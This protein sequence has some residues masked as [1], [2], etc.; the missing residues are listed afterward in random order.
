MSVR[1]VFIF[2]LLLIFTAGLVYCLWP[3]IVGLK[4]GYESHVAVSEFFELA[5]T[6]E[7]GKPGVSFEYVDAPVT[8]ESVPNDYPELFAAMQEYNENIYA[9]GQ[10]GL[11]DAWAYQQPSFN[12]TA[13]GVESN[14]IGV[15]N[16]PAMNVELPIYLGATSENMAAGAVHL[17]Q[18]S[19]P[20]GGENTNCVIAAHRGWYGAPYFR[21][22]DIL[23]IG[24]EV[25]ITNLWETLTYRVAEVKIIDPDD[26]DE[27]LIQ[28]GRELLTL[29]TCHPYAS[30]GLYRYVVY[31]ERVPS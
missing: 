14:T 10:S 29:V 27:I 4:L 31:C 11:C 9:T 2:F 30:G 3:Q 6:V 26:I 12:L 19:L 13:Y 28:P 1:K 22:I 16:I 20:I 7:A 24:D 25:R 17:S 21:Y 18:T 15:I 8:E 5:E 23:K